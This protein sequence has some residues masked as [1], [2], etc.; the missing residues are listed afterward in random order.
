MTEANQPRLTEAR[1][2]VRRY[3]YARPT[4]A[5]DAATITHGLRVK[6]Q[7]FDQSEIEVAMHFWAGCA[8]PQITIVRRSEADPSKYYQITTAGVVA[9]ETEH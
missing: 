8:P 6:G 3:L 7:N 1:Y 4:L 2:A 5:Q 9:H